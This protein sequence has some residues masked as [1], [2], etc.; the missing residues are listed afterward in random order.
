MNLFNADF[1]L[2]DKTTETHLK[3][4]IATMA[5]LLILTGTLLVYAMP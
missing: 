1:D 2:I 4:G 5:G 3:A